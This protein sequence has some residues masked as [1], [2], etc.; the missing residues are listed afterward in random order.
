MRGF[1]EALASFPDSDVR[2]VGWASI[3]PSIN[4]IRF[5]WP[6]EGS[7][8]C[9]WRFGIGLTRPR[10]CHASAYECGSAEQDFRTGDG[11]EEPGKHLR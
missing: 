9:F 8:S 5:E 2:L 6:P 7:D 11:E 3:R 1:L 4:K 10:Y